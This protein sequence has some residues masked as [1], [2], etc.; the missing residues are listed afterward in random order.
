MTN[1]AAA[2]LLA[3]LAADTRKSV[4]LTTDG[5][6]DLIVTWYSWDNIGVR[7]VDGP[8]VGSVRCAVGTLRD[9]FTHRGTC[10]TYG[11]YVDCDSE[12]EALATLINRHDTYLACEHAAEACG[13]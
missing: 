5:G 13:F 2:A 6:C 3:T 7:S 4:R 11:T 9:R 1:D 10:G 8:H 12:A